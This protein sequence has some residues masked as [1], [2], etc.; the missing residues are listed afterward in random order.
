MWVVFNVWVIIKFG[1]YFNIVLGVLS[2]ML[3]FYKFVGIK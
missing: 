3:F 1:Y 2:N